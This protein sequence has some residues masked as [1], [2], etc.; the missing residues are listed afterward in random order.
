M[1][2]QVLGS[3]FQSQSTS[4]IKEKETA[5][6]KVKENLFLPNWGQWPCGACWLP[7]PLHAAQWEAGPFLSLLGPGFGLRAA[8]PLQQYP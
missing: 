1:L 3:F 8:R 4:K 6:F 2:L 7:A 5:H